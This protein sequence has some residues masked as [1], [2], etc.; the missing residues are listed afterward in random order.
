MSKRC[1]NSQEGIARAEKS[2]A[3]FPGLR[4]PG[5]DARLYFGAQNL[6][7][8]G[9]GRSFDLLTSG[10]LL[11]HVKEQAPVSFVDT[12]HQS[13]ELE[14]NARFLAGTAPGDVIG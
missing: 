9:T 8:T 10:Q 11:R 12:A 5:T 2:L 14:E 3:P 7:R 1:A 6:E 4:L 13:T